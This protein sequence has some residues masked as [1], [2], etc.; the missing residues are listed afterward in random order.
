[1]AKKITTISVLLISIVLVSLYVISSTYSVIINVIDKGNKTEIINKITIRDVLTDDNGSYNQTYYEV[2]NE[3]DITEEE[4]N[5]LI[6]SIPLNNALETII[7]N[8]VE[9]KLHNQN[10]MSADEIYHLITE[11]V[12]SD[13]NINME[14]KNKVIQ[15][16]GIYLNDVIDYIYNFNISSIGELS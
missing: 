8:V 2:K 14:L 4:S 3:L 1:M 16:T 9:Y 6:D 13:N 5:I 15:K 11:S 7:G 12:N 10:R